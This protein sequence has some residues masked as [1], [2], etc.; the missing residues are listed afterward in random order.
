MKITKTEQHVLLR[1]KLGEY[2]L[3]HEEFNS[4]G[5]DKSIEL[6]EKEINKKDNSS[7]SGE[8]INFKQAS[9]LGF[10]SYGIKDFAKMLEIDID[11]EYTI[12][13]LN[14]KLTIDAL[15]EYPDECIKLF[16]KNTLKYLG[17]VEGILDEATVSL[18]LR[19]EFI[20]EKTLHLLFVR[21]A[22]SC[23]DNFENEYPDDKRP[24]QAIEAKEAWILGD[25]NDEQ[26]Y[27]AHRAAGY[28][29]RSAVNY[30]A[31]YAAYCATSSAASYDARY[32]A[33]CAAYSAA[34]SATSCATSSAA[35]SAAYSAARKG[36]VQ[37][38]FEELTNQEAQEKK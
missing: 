27:V 22:Y 21:F 14:E 28:A 8:T 36:Q 15:K 13:E 3:S 37:M 4:L 20:P 7:F 33:H 11:G 16:G 5:K 12:Q 35:S 25:I 2:H 6:A 30:D 1:N 26:L 38:I 24:R 10:C 18:V 17:G 34:S 32:A 9:A 29:A 19:K 31:R 23:L